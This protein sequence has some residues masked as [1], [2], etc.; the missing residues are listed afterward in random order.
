MHQKT[1]KEISSFS[2]ISSLFILS[3][4]AV[5]FIVF[6]IVQTG[7]NVNL[8]LSNKEKTY[9]DSI[10]SPDFTFSDITL[11][12]IVF[13]FQP[14]A[15]K[16]FESLDLSPQGFKAKFRVLE[17]KV[18]QNEEEINRL[19]QKQIDEIDKLQQFMYRFLLTFQEADK[20]KE[21]KQHSENKTEFKFYVTQLAAVEL[22]R[23][24]NLNLIKIKLPYK[25]VGE[26]EKTSNYAK[27]ENDF[28]D[29]TQCCEITKLGEEFLDKLEKINNP[30]T[31]NQNI[32]A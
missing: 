9:I 7:I 24:R 5:K 15:S 4:L 27:G 1:P 16:I 14:Q 25:S 13:L 10:K 28:I 26:L 31:Q 20:L 17:S 11:I 22:R 19:Q 30:D 8:H 21:L 12:V 29:L 6:P 3:Y 2:K 32:S 18:A 23:L